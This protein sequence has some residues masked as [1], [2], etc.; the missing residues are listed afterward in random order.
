M[1]SPSQYHAGEHPV[2]KG[3]GS[4]YGLRAERY[5]A[6]SGMAFLVTAVALPENAK[7]LLF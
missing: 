4:G 6:I 2:K 7:G 1:L 5:K 3:A